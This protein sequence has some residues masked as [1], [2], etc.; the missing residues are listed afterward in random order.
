M[1]GLVASTCNASIREAE[2]GA[3]LEL[4]VSGRISLKESKAH[5]TTHELVSGHSGD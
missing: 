3:S 2:T 4:E 1:L 5:V